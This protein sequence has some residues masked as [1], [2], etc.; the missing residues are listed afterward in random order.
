[1]KLGEYNGKY[2]WR[3]G[4]G[5]GGPPACPDFSR[6]GNGEKKSASG[7]H[8]NVEIAKA[9][10]SHIPTARR[11]GGS[12]YTDISNGIQHAGLRC[13]YFPASSFSIVFSNSSF[14]PKPSLALRWRNNIGLI[15]CRAVQPSQPRFELRWLYLAQGLLTCGM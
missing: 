14:L 13:G 15:S 5:H 2:S 11:W 1:V 3:T 4:H 10:I 6:S 7:A 12:T 8:G 9:A